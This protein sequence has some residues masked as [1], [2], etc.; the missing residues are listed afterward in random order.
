MEVVLEEHNTPSKV[1]DVV[2]GG[3]GGGSY[4]GE[5]GALF[6][7]SGSLKGKS[8][9]QAVGEEEDLLKDPKFVYTSFFDRVREKL[10]I[11]QS[12]VR[13][14]LADHYRKTGRVLN[15]KITKVIVSLDSSGKLVSV[16]IMAESGS[17]MLDQEALKAFRVAEPFP[18]PPK[19]LI[20]DGIVSFDWSFVIAL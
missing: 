15:N 7:L 12:S 9:P 3:K 19:E 18:N 13:S 16:R 11:W 8:S 5:P 10:D 20:K 14:K 4:S 2:R 6:K 1:L 17:E